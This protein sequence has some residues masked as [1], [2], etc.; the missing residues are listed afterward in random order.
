MLLKPS[1]Q[2]PRTVT[3]ENEIVLE[4]TFSPIKF[5]PNKINTDRRANIGIWVRNKRR[6]RS[7][8]RTPR[9]H[10][11]GATPPDRR[12]GGPPAGRG[13]GRVDGPD[14]ARAGDGRGAWPKGTMKAAGAAAG[15]AGA[16]ASPPRKSRG[17]PSFA[18]FLF[19]CFP[20]LARLYSIASALPSFAFAT[21]EAPRAGLTAVGRPFFGRAADFC[22]GSH[23]KNSGKTRASRK[24]RE[25]MSIG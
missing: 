18:A 10:G 6:L 16:A 3:R 22:A 2:S 12:Q 4:M 25:H 14:A 23:G 20:S 13:G 8:R 15:A 17:V 21:R 24:C 7:A 9:G 5:L 11:V 19:S 1:G